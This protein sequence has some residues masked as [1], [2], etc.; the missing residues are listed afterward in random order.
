MMY[1]ITHSLHLMYGVKVELTVTKVISWN[2]HILLSLLHY[3]PIFIL[4][5]S[6]CLASVNEGPMN[7]RLFGSDTGM[8][9]ACTLCIVTQK[10]LLNQQSL[11]THYLLPVMLVLFNVSFMCSFLYV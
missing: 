3:I 8:D 7:L 10:A 1:L 4:S 6:Y 5:F 2:I 9:Q 11:M